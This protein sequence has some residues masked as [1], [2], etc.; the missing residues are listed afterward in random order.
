MTDFSEWSQ[1][2]LASLA[3]EL[4]EENKV[5]RKQVRDLLDALRKEWIKQES[6]NADVQEGD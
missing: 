2:S 4:N 5:L 1:E 6:T 3:S